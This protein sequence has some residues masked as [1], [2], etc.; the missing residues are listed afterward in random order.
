MSKK[1]LCYILPSFDLGTDSHFYSLYD[2]IDKAAKDLD[3]FLIIEKNYSDIKFFKNVRDIKTQKF[4][5]LPLRILENFIFVIMARMRGY[6]NFYVHYSFISAIN[7]SLVC[8]LTGGK[9]W[10]WNCGMMWTFTKDRFT[11][12]MLKVILRLVNFLVTGTKSLAEGYSQNYK[13]PLKKIKIMPNWVDLER[14]QQKFDKEVIF[15]NFSIPIGKKYVLFVHRLAERKGAQYI[16]PIAKKISEEVVF[17]VAGDGP[18][19]ETLQEEIKQANL[20]NIILLGKISNQ[21]VPELMGMA[22]IFLMPSEE[23]GFPR[24]LIECMASGL[25]YVASDV[26]GVREISPE[27]EYDYLYPAGK[28]KQFVIGINDILVKGKNIFEKSLFKKAAEF[29]QNNALR[30]FISIIKHE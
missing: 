11:Q 19:K 15:K 24:V 2:F 4:L 22:D 17:L 5:F 27:I 23:E 21:L 25:P 8:R 18:Y 9:V 14:F 3:I 29:E 12:I 20:K 7:S 10:Y 6:K 1:K 28:I 13:I 26:G 30:I 16:V